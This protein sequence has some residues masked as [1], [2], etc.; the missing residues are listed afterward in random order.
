[1]DTEEKFICPTCGKE[2][3]PLHP[4]PYAEE[5]NNNYEDV[6]NCCNECMRQCVYDI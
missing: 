2:G 5:I 3:L 1:M 6:C 4:C